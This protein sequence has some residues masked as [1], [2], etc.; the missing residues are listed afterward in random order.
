[1]ISHASN[2]R[3]HSN[4]SQGRTTEKLI[5][6]YI[7]IS[8]HVRAYVRFPTGQKRCGLPVRRQ[9]PQGSGQPERT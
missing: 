7:I 5:A 8:T 2:T 3:S 4:R 6:L 1:M 9:Q